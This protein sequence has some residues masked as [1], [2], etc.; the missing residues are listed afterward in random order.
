MT[1][2]AKGFWIS[3]LQAAGW[4]TLMLAFV[5]GI[6]GMY[7]NSQLGGVWFG[8]GIMAGVWLVGFFSAVGIFVLANMADDANRTKRATE[9]MAKATAD[10]AASQFLL[11]NIA[12]DLNR[13]K[14]ATSALAKTTASSPNFGQS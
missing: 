7:L 5:G 6:I 14:Q 1:D 2:S 11:A 13:T 4:L 12:D 10:I 8:L 9:K 3:A